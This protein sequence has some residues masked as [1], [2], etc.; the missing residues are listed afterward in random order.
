MII[1][2]LLLQ[3]SI[4]ISKEGLTSESNLKWSSGVSR[5][6]ELIILFIEFNI[7]LIIA[8]HR[9]EEGLESRAIGRCRS[10][11]NLYLSNSETIRNEGLGVGWHEFVVFTLEIV[12]WKAIHCFIHSYNII[13]FIV[14]KITNGEQ[15]LPDYLLTRLLLQSHVHLVKVYI[16]SKMRAFSYFLWALSR[17]TWYGTRRCCICH[18]ATEGSV[19]AEM[20]IGFWL[21]GLA[22]GNRIGKLELCIVTSYL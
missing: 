11:C 16:N 12:C 2:N 20:I 8:Q 22:W 3:V 14:V 9:H 19:T 17:T 21:P 1:P 15:P 13:L 18:F 4:D 10:L 7:G 6:F 5:E